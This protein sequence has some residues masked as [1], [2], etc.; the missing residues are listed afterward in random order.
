MSKGDISAG[1][2]KRVCFRFMSLP[3]RADSC[4][5]Y[6]SREAALAWQSPI[7]TLLVGWERWEGVVRY[8]GVSSEVLKEI[9]PWIPLCMGLGLELI[10]MILPLSPRLTLNQV[11]SSV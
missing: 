7:K 11:V 8:P 4:Q 1:P 9:L 10:I 6:F 5:H 2:G 3:P